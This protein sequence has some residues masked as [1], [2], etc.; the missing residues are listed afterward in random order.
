MAEA[1]PHMQTLLLPFPD[2]SDALHGLLSPLDLLCLGDPQGVYLEELDKPQLQTPYHMGGPAGLP[3]Q[4]LEADGNAWVPV[5]LD[6]S[7]SALLCLCP[8][9][10]KYCRR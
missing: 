1:L 5:P 2:A 6:S 7:T 9:L 3:V 8:V 4:A 10:P